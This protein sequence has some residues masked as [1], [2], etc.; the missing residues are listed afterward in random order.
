[1]SRFVQRCRIIPIRRGNV[2]LTLKVQKTDCF[3]F[4]FRMGRVKYL[5]A[6]GD[7]DRHPS[8]FTSAQSFC[9]SLSAKGDRL[10]SVDFTFFFFKR[11]HLL[12]PFDYF[13]AYKVPS[14]KGLTL[15]GKNVLPT[16]L[17]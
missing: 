6:H 13:P 11:R 8:A 2:I 17:L 10:H 4:Q 1:M 16:V 14:E 7:N 5:K 3:F 15:N 9:N 12:R